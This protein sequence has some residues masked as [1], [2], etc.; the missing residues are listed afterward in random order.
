MLTLHDFT[1][2]FAKHYIPAPDLNQLEIVA[3]IFSLSVQFC[4]VHGQA[5]NVEEN[6]P[7]LLKL[8]QL[9]KRNVINPTRIL[10]DYIR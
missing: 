7:L 1:C 6:I 2:L 3:K 4:A 9:I 8:S 10:K 5:T